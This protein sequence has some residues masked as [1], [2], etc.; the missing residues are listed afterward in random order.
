MFQIS[1]QQHKMINKN[2]VGPTYFLSTLWSLQYFKRRI[3][4]TNR[5]KL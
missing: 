4:R 1:R 2:Q 5:K 3:I